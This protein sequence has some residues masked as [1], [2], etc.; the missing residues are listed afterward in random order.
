MPVLGSIAG[1]NLKMAMFCTSAP[2]L[3]S[4]SAV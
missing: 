4:A 2:P 1:V 3:S